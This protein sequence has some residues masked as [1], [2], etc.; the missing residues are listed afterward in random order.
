MLD[1]AIEGNDDSKRAAN[2]L[3]RFDGSGYL[4][5]GKISWDDTGSLYIDKN[6]VVGDNNE[7]LNSLVTMLADFRS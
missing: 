6:V 5:K 3:F 4:S 7:T 2:S 1:R